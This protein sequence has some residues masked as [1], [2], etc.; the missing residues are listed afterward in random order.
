MSDFFREPEHPV[1]R[2]AAQCIACCWPI[3]QSEKYVRQ[4][5][6]WDG[7]WFVNRFHAECFDVLCSDAEGEFSPGSFD[8]PE[9]LRAI[10]A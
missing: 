2:K 1:A 7:R 10:A 4:T 5:G 3:E 6:I 9:R 8:P